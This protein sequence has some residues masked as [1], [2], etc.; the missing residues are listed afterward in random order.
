MLSTVSYKSILEAKNNLAPSQ[1]KVLAFNN[2]NY[3]HVRDLLS[4]ELKKE[5][6]GLEVGSANYIR[7]SPN[8]FIRAKGLAEDSF[9]PNL[10][11][12]SVKPIRPQV[13]VNYQLKEG[14]ILISKD[15]NIGETIILDKDYPNYMPSGAIYKLPVEKNKFYLLAF[16]KSPI[17]KNQLDLMVPKGA[18]IRHAKTL[19]L[20]CKI[21]FP[22]Q[23]NSVEVVEYIEVLMK[24]VIEKEKATREKNET[25]FQLIDRELREH[26]GGQKYTYIPPTLSDLKIRKRLDTGMYGEDYQSM[27]F[28]I[29]NYANGNSTFGELGYKISRG[30]NLQVTAIGRSYYSEIDRPNFYHLLLSKNFTDWMTAEKC[31]Y[32]GNPKKLKTIKEGDVIFSCRGDLGRIVIFCEKTENTITNID[33]VHITNADSTLENKIFVGAFLNYLRR[34]GYL[35][36]ISITGSGADSFT[37]YQFELIRFPNFSA[38]AQK[39][40]AGLF[41]NPVEYPKTS[42]HNFEVEHKKWNLSAGVYDLDK[43]MKKI[44]VHLNEV[45]EQIVENEKVDI[46]FSFLKN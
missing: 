42:L 10:S 44:K 45:L 5:D 28:L 22:N 24:S 33:N 23:K 16:L 17:F 29:K 37:K 1:L 46:D 7:K 15:S 2:K 9:L 11:G 8:Y 20:D 40:I 38:M 43:S 34:V 13:F 26:Q 39:K 32:L 4:R 27:S 30:Q 36:L 35:S 14:D 41:L 12:E 18:T 19:F 21:P 31:S 3:R 25:I 6:N